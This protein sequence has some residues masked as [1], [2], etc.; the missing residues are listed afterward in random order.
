MKKISNNLVYHLSEQ[1]CYGSVISVMYQEVK[2]T[3]SFIYTEI[4][5]N[6]S[7]VEQQYKLSQRFFSNRKHLIQFNRSQQVFRKEGIIT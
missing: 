2:K 1:F 4:Y 5:F 7:T 6:S 3:T